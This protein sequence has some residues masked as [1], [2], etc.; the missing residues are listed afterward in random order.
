MFRGFLSFH[1]PIVS[2]N[3][4]LTCFLHESI[5]FSY[6][7]S[8]KK[9]VLYHVSLTFMSLFPFST[10]YNKFLQFFFYVSNIIIFCS[11]FMR[12]GLYGFDK[13]FTMLLPCFRGFETCLLLLFFI[14]QRYVLH[15]FLN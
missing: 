15:D 14:F 7:H 3:M 8:S 13:R 12:H 6:F 11:S 2:R 4:F 1:I 9:H 10:L 5:N